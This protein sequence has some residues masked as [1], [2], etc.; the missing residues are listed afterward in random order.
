MAII[1]KTLWCSKCASEQPQIKGRGYYLC[2]T[3]FTENDGKHPAEH[4]Q[5]VRA[6]QNALHE[7]TRKKMNRQRTFP[8]LPHTQHKRMT[9]MGS[10]SIKLATFKRP[11]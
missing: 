11:K 8:Q 9:V 6:L 5:A 3:C 2:K 1:R 10:R 7:E 4:C